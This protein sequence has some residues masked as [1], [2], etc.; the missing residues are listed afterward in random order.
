MVLGIQAVE[1][2]ATTITTKFF[3]CSS[4]TWSILGENRSV[5]PQLILYVTFLCCFSCVIS[6]IVM[7][8]MCTF[9]C[10][11]G[12]FKMMLLFTML[13]WSIAR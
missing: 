2:A 11:K 1:N 5:K 12:H 3:M 7:S 4:L 6:S 13:H 9:S 10:V 8:D